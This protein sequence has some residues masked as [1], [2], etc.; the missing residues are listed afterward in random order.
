M[1]VR[2]CVRACMRAFVRVLVYSHVLTLS[3]GTNLR[4]FCFI[5]DRFIRFNTNFT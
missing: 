1:Y 5:I 3:F 4:V 2:A